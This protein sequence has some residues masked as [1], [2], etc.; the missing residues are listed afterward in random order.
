MQDCSIRGLFYI[1]TCDIGFKNLYIR[2][3]LCIWIADKYK[4]WLLL[5]VWVFIEQNFL[6]LCHNYTF[7][8]ASAFW[9]K[10]PES[11][12][13]INIFLYEKYNYDSIGSLGFYFRM[14]DKHVLRWDKLCEK[15]SAFWA[16]W[17]LIIV[18]QCLGKTDI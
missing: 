2:T 15:H 11:N 14:W 7:R 6:R 18:C 5:T 8:I 1:A 9:K 17:T 12:F 13:D 3:Y 4:P 16:S 10:S